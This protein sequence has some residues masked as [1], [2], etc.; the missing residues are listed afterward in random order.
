MLWKF[1]LKTFQNSKN[2]IWM[3]KIVP[4]LP[5]W[6]ISTFGA[7]KFLKIFLSFFSKFLQM[8]LAVLFK[9]F[10]VLWKL[11]K[12]EQ[13]VISVPQWLISTF[14]YTYLSIKK[15]LYLSQIIYKWSSYCSQDCT[16]DF[17]NLKK[18]KL[19]TLVPNC[20]EFERIEGNC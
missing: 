6:H 15:F 13:L 9:T 1:A 14:G 7:L 4:S 18:L 17:T 3:K 8:A 2:W 5:R 20:N 11:S 16:N 19:G 10:K 12:N